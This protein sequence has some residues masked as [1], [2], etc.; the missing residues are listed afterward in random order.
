VIPTG[1]RERRERKRRARHA[2]RW[3]GLAQEERD[4]RKLLGK[5]GKVG[6]CHSPVHYCT[7]P[8]H[9]SVVQGVSD[10]PFGYTIALE[11]DPPRSFLWVESGG[12]IGIKIALSIEPVSGK[13][14]KVY[15]RFDARGLSEQS[16]RAASVVVNYLRHV[17]AIGTTT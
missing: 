6:A 5:F 9:V 2:E 8:L 3:R 1:E 10:G 17:G 16:R 11:G 13:T 7:R 15:P 4:L 12:S 14:K